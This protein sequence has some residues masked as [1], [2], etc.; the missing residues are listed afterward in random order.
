MESLPGTLRTRSC[1]PGAVGRE[2]ERYRRSGRCDNVDVDTVVL[3][4][5]RLE[6][7][8]SKPGTSSGEPSRP[9][10]NATYDQRTERIAPE[11]R[12]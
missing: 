12:S 2:T 9:P 11:G 5:P 6:R 10:V 7:F 8:R 3:I 4:V 1:R